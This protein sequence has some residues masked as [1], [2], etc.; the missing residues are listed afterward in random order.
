MGNLQTEL[1]AARSELEPQ[2][3]ALRS[4][5]GALNAAI[6]L[7]GEER[8]DALPMQKALAKLQQAAAQVE[9]ESLQ[10]A[11][12]AFA[13]ATQTA[14]DNLAFEFAAALRA[15]LEARGVEVTGRPP[16]LG[17]G[18]LAFNIDIAAH[19]GQWFYGRE[20]LTGPIPLS[21]T[22]ILKAYELH[23]KQI[24]ERKIEIEA[25]LKELHQAWQDCVNKR[26]VSPA[27]K[28][29]NIVET[30]AQLTLNR[31]LPRF[32]N[33][34]ARRTFKDYERALFVRDLVILQEQ[35]ATSLIVDGE[36]RQLRLGVATKSQAEQASRSIWL[37]T[38]ALEGQYYSDV[39]FA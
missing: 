11:V 38:S 20:P 23:S 28:R 8:A 9:S 4:V 6:R 29:I 16:V 21:L 5:I 26:K 36:T 10:A 37:P 35:S 12:S 14:L 33:A 32:W 27:G 3:K 19:K 13:G 17:A 7:A 39:I 22:A 31:Q 25:L 2:F 34:P 1:Q 15:E 24:G 30:Y 18:L